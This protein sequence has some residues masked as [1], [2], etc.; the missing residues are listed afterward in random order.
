MQYKKE[1]LGLEKFQQQELFVNMQAGL[2]SG[3]IA[4]AATNGFEAIT[5][6]K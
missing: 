5:V 4:A 3:I 6:A 1:T 2:L